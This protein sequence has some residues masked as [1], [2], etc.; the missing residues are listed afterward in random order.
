MIHC[1]GSESALAILGSVALHLVSRGRISS[2]RRRVPHPY[3]VSGQAAGHPIQQQHAGKA[4][5]PVIQIA[6]Y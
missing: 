6:N 1:L 2:G 3:T 4:D 5:S